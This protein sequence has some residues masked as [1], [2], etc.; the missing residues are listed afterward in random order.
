MGKKNHFVTLDGFFHVGRAHQDGASFVFEL[1]QH[2]PEFRPGHRVHTGGRFVQNEQWR[3][4]HE[5]TN[6]GQFLFHT[7]G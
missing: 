4:I 2:F 1:L 3:R 5:H 6:E 7:T